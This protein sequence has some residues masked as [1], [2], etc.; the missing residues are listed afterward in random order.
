LG[1]AKTWIQIFL[2]LV[3][4]A[5]GSNII[6]NL[7]D[8]SEVNWDL[9][10]GQ[11]EIL[12]EYLLN[13]YT[14]VNLEDDIEFTDLSILDSD[15]EGKEIF[16]TGELHG[17]K[18]N[19]ELRWKFLKYFKEKT[20][21][22]YYLCEL[23]YSH[24][25]FIN[26]YLDTG[27]LNILE[28]MYKSLKG[29][30]EWNKDNYNHWRKLYEY[31]K[32]LPVDK[33]IRVVGVDIEHQIDNAYRY[34]VDVLPEREV[35][36]EIKE[37]VEEI[38]DILNNY[39]HSYSSV[40]VT[41]SRKLLKD[42]EEKENIYREY[43]GDNFTGFKFVNLNV[44]NTA[45]AYNRDWNEYQW[46]NTRDKMIYENFIILLNE[47]PEGKYYGQWGLN[48]AFQSKEDEVMWF[49]AHLNSDESKYKG[50]ILTIAYFYDACQRMSTVENRTYS[51]SE[52][53]FIPQ[54]FKVANDLTS[55]NMNIY[56]LNSKGSPLF[57]LPMNSTF[58]GKAL[59]DKVVDFFQ[60]IVCIKNSKATEP[61]NDEYN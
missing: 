21:F 43:L 6:G 28:E 35:P 48:H 4:V 47:L 31:N 15:L 2:I 1:K 59:E 18:A 8:S 10:G 30:Y 40:A 14:I 33:R 55:S 39:N 25:Y 50:K 3:V 57:Q 13:N 56:K 36:G 58:T 11:Y 42:M 7:L 41:H 29:T 27:D 51:T 52:L 22:K 12:E 34:L 61:L 9:P 38:K 26:K 60:Y 32:T 19:E 17:V 37:N 16:F 45:K 5:I 23:G 24:A 53:D 54:I 20:D 49:G 46:N 44:L